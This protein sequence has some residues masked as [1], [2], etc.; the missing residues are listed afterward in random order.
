MGKIWQ[1]IRLRLG[2]LGFVG[3]GGVLVSAAFSVTIQIYPFTGYTFIS[4]GVA[5]VLFWAFIVLGISGL[6]CIVVALI[7]RKKPAEIGKEKVIKSR[8]PIETLT[9][10]HRRL[11]ELQ[12][13]KASH[14]NVTLNELDKASW[15]FLDKLGIVPLRD[16]PKY[17]LKIKRRVQRNLPRPPFRQRFRF[18]EWSKYKQMARERGLAVGLELQRELIAE[19]EWTL[20]DVYKISEWLDDYD[21]GVKKLR[22]N[23]LNWGNM[24]KSI[25]DYLGDDTLRELIGNHVE[26]SRAY[27]NVC[28]INHYSER[29]G[30]RNSFLAELNKVLVGSPIS[31]V[32]AELALGEI[33]SEIK[34]RLVE[35]TKGGM[36]MSD[37]KEDNTENEK[38]TI[39]KDTRIKL[40]A[41][42]TEEATGMDISTPAELDNVKVDMTAENVKRATGLNV[43]AVNKEFAIGVRMIACSCGNIFSR[44]T[45]H[46]YKPVI[47]CPK[48]GR[49]YKD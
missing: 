29:L 31:P 12:E 41:K 36:V 4:P 40:D 22:D 39:V 30:E 5:G 33:I 6:L 23:D 16:K 7:K 10:M 1:G 18:K 28:L 11:V 32:K 17:M 44:V 26:L 9:K 15:V 42:D 27:N 21:W 19:Q 34:K 8:K 37:D 45:T 38:P 13:E 3:V 2:R 20:S 14:T 35:M 48:C 43:T 25:G 47:K 46:G 24:W 49:E